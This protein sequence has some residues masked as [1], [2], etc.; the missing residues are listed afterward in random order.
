[1]K[2]RCLIIL[3]VL[4][5]AA[6]LECTQKDSTH[7][8]E[9]PIETTVCKIIE[10]PSAFNN[11]LV[12]VRG[13][14]AVSFEFSTLQEEGCPDA[15]WFAVADG[16]G[17]P[18]LVITVNGSGKPG[19]KNS[20]GEPVKPI[21]VTLVCDSNYEKF[22]RYMAV[23]AEGKPCINDLSKPTPTDCAVDRVTATFIGRID[24]VSKKIHAARLK[25]SLSS[26]P[27][28]RGFGQMGMFDAQLVVAEVEDVE[29]VDSFG[30]TKP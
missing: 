16:S 28:N 9:K 25:K 15:I 7:I 17:P 30:R 12:K 2:S 20:K 26:H 6:S 4:F 10:N 1:M 11:K 21:P 18:G 23:K 13:Y 24:G 3:L 14:V 22:E 29:A 19:S 5:S 8:R 27:D